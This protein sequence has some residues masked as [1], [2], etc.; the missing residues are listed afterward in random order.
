[1]ATMT[2][3][4]A[5]AKDQQGQQ[6]KLST[7]KAKKTKLANCVICEKVIKEIEG[8]HKG[9]DSILCEGEYQGWMHRVCAGIS[10][11][12]LQKANDSDE[13]FYCH[14][15]KSSRQEAEISNLKSTINNLESELAQ[16]KTMGYQAQPQQ[17]SEDHTHNQPSFASFVQSGQPIS[18][19]THAIRTTQRTD[20]NPECKFNLVVY[21]INEC[22]EGSSRYT[23]ITKDTQ[24]ITSLIQKIDATIPG[25]SIRD[26]VRMGKYTKARRRPILVKMSRSCEVSAI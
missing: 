6:T 19:R 10:K 13:P 15:C 21:G 4:A 14:Y 24:D 1:M 3:R 7:I 11:N 22:P 5:T 12:A 16:L 18:S 17:G 20:H 23:H 9:Q 26:C 25:Q 2:T 8:S